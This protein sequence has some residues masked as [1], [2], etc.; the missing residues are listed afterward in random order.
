M[1][2]EST[3][4]S[5]CERCRNIDYAKALAYG[6]AIRQHPGGIIIDDDASRLVPPL[7]TDCTMCKLLSTTVVWNHDDLLD[8]SAF[9]LRAFSFFSHCRGIV[10]PKLEARDIPVMLPT[11]KL[12]AISKA[13]QSEFYDH[14]EA[15][16]VT[17]YP[18]SNQPALFRPQTISESFDFQTARQWIKNCEE[19]HERCHHDPST[20]FNPRLE[21]PGMKLID[22]EKMEITEAGPSMRWVALSYVWAPGKTGFASKV[23]EKLPHEISATIKDSIAVTKLLGYRYIWV[24]KYCI[25]HGNLSESKDH[26]GKMHLIYSNA[27]CV[28]IATAGSDENF[29]LPGVGFK[30]KSKQKVVQLDSITIMNTGPEPVHEVEE[31][32]WWTRGWTFQETVFARRRLVFTQYQTIFECAQA[33]W[34]EAI[35]GLECLEDPQSLDWKSWMNGLFFSSQYRDPSPGY[36]LHEIFTRE[37]MDTRYVRQLI[38]LFGLL[39]QYTARD[40]TYDSDSLNGIKAI[41]Q[42]RARHEPRS[43]ILQGLLCIPIDGIKEL[44]EPLIFASLSWYH[45]SRVDARRRTGFPSWTWAGWAGAVNWIC[46]PYLR[47]SSELLLGLRGVQLE[48][49]DGKLLSALSGMLPGESLDESIVALHFESRLVPTSLFNIKGDPEDWNDFAVG[50]GKCL[51]A[52]MKPPTNSPS[53]LLRHLDS[54]VWGCLHLGDF[55]VGSKSI[56]HRF[57]MIVEWHGNQR[58]T[59]VGALL[60]DTALHTRGAYRSPFN[61]ETARRKSR[62]LLAGSLKS[63]I[64]FRNGSCSSYSRI[65]RKLTLGA[66]TEGT[67][68][69][70]II[71]AA[72]DI[73]K[74]GAAYSTDGDSSR[75]SRRSDD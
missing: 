44:I 9:T 43:V 47:S 73:L 17:C 21:V 6:D 4:K 1:S 37:S 51:I 48:S 67:F 14:G 13:G 36:P 11:R 70:P 26:I 19:D 74:N 32:R 52:G 2:P 75:G 25:N 34:T 50:H 28:I 68:Q 22:C 72:H 55:W 20:T 53:E 57:L 5:L 69:L 7:T 31:S 8:P 66:S 56:N 46:H 65:A 62:Y 10:R 45:K 35:G 29:G 71:K 39:K 23:G 16:Y 27:E 30:R 64:G 60:V 33:S 58:A 24:D 41:L 63:D 40:L 42:L 61:I 3:C 49:R 18:Q 38:D 12:Q 54:G 15:G 59:R